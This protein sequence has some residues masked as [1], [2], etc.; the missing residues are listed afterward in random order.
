MAY[1][2]PERSLKKEKFLRKQRSNPESLFE[3]LPREV[4]Q[5]LFVYPLLLRTN[6]ALLVCSL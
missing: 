6:T 1:L 3:S 4:S 2:S 5:I